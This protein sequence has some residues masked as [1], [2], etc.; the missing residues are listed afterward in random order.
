MNNWKKIG[1]IVFLLFVV[2]LS[3]NYW[4]PKTLR[5]LSQNSTTIQTLADFTQILL[6]LGTFI[7]GYFGI[8]AF[9]QERNQS[10]NE[11]QTSRTVPENPITGSDNSMSIETSS[12]RDSL[13]KSLEMARRALTHLELKAAGYTSLT[14]P[15]TLIIELEDKRQEVAMFEEQLH[16]LDNKNQ[17]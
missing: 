5:F 14:M 2:T 3:S 15:T 16:K 1:I 4:L 12:N 11:T 13:V 6:W 7:F 8:K 17:S 10:N 9:G